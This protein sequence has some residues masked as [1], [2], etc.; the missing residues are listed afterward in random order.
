VNR[1]LFLVGAMSLAALITNRQ[2]IIKEGIKIGLRSVRKVGEISSRLVE[3]LQDLA[4]AASAELD[5]EDS[6]GTAPR[7]ER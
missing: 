5:Q 6:G 3:D 7:A 1:T 4:A 2:S